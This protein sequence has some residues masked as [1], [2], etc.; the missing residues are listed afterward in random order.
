MIVLDTNVI[1]ALMHAVPDT[2]VIAWLDQQPRLSI[3][4]TSVTIFEVQYG[5]SILPSGKRRDGLEIAF[6]TLVNDL[7]EA[8][9]AVFDVQ[10]ATQAAMISSEQKRLGL[11][12][13]MRDIMIAGI[14]SANAAKLATRNLRDFENSNVSLIN[15]WQTG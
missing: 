14:C 10:S 6:K 7:L 15:P 4:T 12:V 2:A 1:S 8:R 5:L 11:N 9:I 3:W 13:D